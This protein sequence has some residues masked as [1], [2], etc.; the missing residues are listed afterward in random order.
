M[1]LSESRWS[2][3]RSR[4]F[5][6]HR[7]LYWFTRTALHAAGVHRSNVVVVSGSRGD[8]AIGK[9]RARIQCGVDLRE[10][11][12]RTRTAVDVVTR[13]LGRAR[14]P[15]EIDRVNRFNAV[16]AESFRGGRTPSAAGKAKSRRHVAAGLGSKHH[17]E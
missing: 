17:V 3:R 4:A 2:G 13:N 8:R 6:V 1:Q 10:R 16:S 15:R 7:D 9:G 12:G 5:L 14:I 11:A